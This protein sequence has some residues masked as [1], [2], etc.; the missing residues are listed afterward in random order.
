MD[1]RENIAPILRFKI[2]RFNTA[3]DAIPDRRAA[4]I[5]IVV[6]DATIAV[7][8][9]M[10]LVNYAIRIIARRQ[11]SADV[12]MDIGANTATIRPTRDSV[13]I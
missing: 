11:K 12:R 13:V 5:G 7:E 10:D 4:H 6:R 3:I 9:D 2:L 1:T 8:R